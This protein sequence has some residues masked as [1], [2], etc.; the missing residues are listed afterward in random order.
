M[1]SPVS[2]VI[3][4]LYMEDFEEQALTSTP[5]MPK[6]WKRYV[7]DTF[8]ILS[9]DKVDIFLQHLN[10]QQPTI[11][12]TME[13]ETNNTIPFLDTLVTRD[14]DGYLS[15]SVYRKPTHTDQ[16]LA[17]DS[18]HPQS[19]KR[20]IVKCLYDRSKHLITKPS[21]VSQEKKHLSSVLVSNGYPFSFVKNITKTKKQTATKEPAPEIKS[22]AVL[23]YVKGLSEALRR[24]LQQQG[25]RTV[26]RSDTTLR[27]HLV[28]PK[29]TVDPAKQDGVVYKIPC[30][31]GKVYIG[32]TGRSMHERI[33][34]HDRDIRL[35]RTQ[36]SGV[37]EHSNA[38]G[39]YPLWDE[40]KFIDRD[41]HWY[42][43]RVK[44]AIH[45]RLHPDNINRDNGIEIPEAWM[46]T[47]K[48]HSNRSVPRRTAEGTI[49]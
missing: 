28:R 6:I 18:H 26:F 41:P 9:R 21:V 37:L 31:C 3:A 19:V 45:I 32:E 8:T 39:H 16:Y 5:C 27:S 2:A 25:I 38:T 4:N 34:E 47:I 44:E 36:S 35:A 29:D 40:V 24:C 49:F 1:G 7:D 11:R 48:L 12:F 17:Y 15:T 42:T 20:G 13:T 33:K 23:P 43:R 30:E 22:T 46:P 14:S 10:S